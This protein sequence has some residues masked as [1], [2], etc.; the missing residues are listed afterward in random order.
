MTWKLTAKQE[1]VMSNLRVGTRFK[2]HCVCAC[3]CACMCV[4]V[5]VRVCVCVCARVCVCAHAKES[6][7]ELNWTGNTHPSQVRHTLQDYETK[8]GLTCL[9]LPIPVKLPINEE[10]HSENS[11][12]SYNALSK[13]STQP[14]Q[15]RLTGGLDFSGCQRP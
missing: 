7:S 12:L 15:G 8:S 2:L 13:Q 11:G 5:C 3:G 9:L 6:A 14:H 1:H 10:A 4:C